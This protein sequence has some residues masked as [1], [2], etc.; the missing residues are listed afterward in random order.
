MTIPCMGGFC[1][2]RDRCAHYRE[3]SRRYEPAE[4][5]CLRGHEDPAPIVGPEAVDNR[6]ADFR[7]RFGSILAGMS[8]EQQAKFEAEMVR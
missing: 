4:R 6:L 5:L 2:S 1:T 3:P 7:R 8:A